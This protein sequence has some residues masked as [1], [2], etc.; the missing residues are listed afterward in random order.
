[1]PE[2]EVGVVVDAAVDVD[3]NVTEYHISIRTGVRS[4]QVLIQRAVALAIHLPEDRQ[5]SLAALST[6]DAVRLVSAALPSNRTTDELVG[7]FYDTKGLAERWHISEQAVHKRADVAHKLLKVMTKDDVALYPA[8]Q[9]DA[10]GGM[11]PNL[12]E[13]MEAFAPGVTDT[14]SVAR[15]LKAPSSRLDG[16]SPADALRSGEQ[17]RVLALASSFSKRLAA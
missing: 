10:G 3:E 8:F 14:W 1:M 2:A 6:T 16:R 9:F 17:D 13:V 11:L 7:P 15:W 12:P 5:E 4:S